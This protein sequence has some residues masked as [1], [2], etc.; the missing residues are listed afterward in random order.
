MSRK[1]P[2]RLAVV[3][4]LLLV[5]CG[6]TEECKT[7]AALKAGRE[8]RLTKLSHQAKLAPQIED[9]AKKQERRAKAETARLGL[10]LSEAEIEAKLKERQA[11]IAGSELVRSYRE[12]PIQGSE[13]TERQT[14]WIVRFPAADLNAAFAHAKE[15]AA[16]PPLLQLV[17]L[18]VDP[19]PG[20]WRL[21]LGR[22]SV[23]QVPVKV[24]PVDPPP[25]PG[26]DEVPERFGFCGASEL[27]AEIA[28]LDEQLEAVRPGAERLTV[29]LPTA[30]TWA[31]IWRRTREKLL[32]NSRARARMQ[33]LLQAVD[34]AGVKLRGVGVAGNHVVLELYRH[35]QTEAKLSTA[36]P[37]EALGSM[38]RMDGPKE[39][40]RL[41][42]PARPERPAQNRAFGLPPPEKLKEAFE[43]AAHDHEDHDHEHH[44]HEHHAH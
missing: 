13:E 22:V 21:Q 3:G 11:A 15:F 37:P 40:L 31:G 14:V 20:F 30:S 2:A 36:L 4:T 16:I 38:K 42:F 44:D 26:L 19:K 33:Q 43:R 1:L 28:Q 10:D 12:L 23:D 25:L 34:K 29:L 27:R 8:A 17:T 41:G 6:Q 39:I 7:L 9:N 5:A 24:D 32:E 18:V 35:P